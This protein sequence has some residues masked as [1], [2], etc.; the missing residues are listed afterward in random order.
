MRKKP[1]SDIS[2]RRWM[3]DGFR[4]VIKQWPQFLIGTMGILTVEFAVLCALPRMAF[5]STFP[6]NLALWTPPGGVWN[7]HE[8][9]VGAASLLVVYL[10]VLGMKNVAAEAASGG[11]PSTR[12][13][14]LPWRNVTRVLAALGYRSVA[15]G[16]RLLML[17]LP[18]IIEWLYCTF[19]PL[20]SLRHR[21]LGIRHS[22]DISRSRTDRVMIRL[23]IYR[24]L[25]VFMLGLAMESVLIGMMLENPTA[26]TVVTILAHLICVPLWTSSSGA[27]YVSL[28]CDEASEQSFSESAFQPASA[29]STTRSALLVLLAGLVVGALALGFVLRADRVLWPSMLEAV[30]E[31][32]RMDP[33]LADARIKVGDIVS[34]A[35]HPDGERI[36]VV[37]RCGLEMRRAADYALLEFVELPVPRYWEVPIALSEDGKLVAVGLE[38]DVLICDL[39]SLGS[40]P[41]HSLPLRAASLE[42]SS[43]GRLLYCAGY[44]DWLVSEVDVQS[45]QIIT[46]W[47]VED[48]VIQKLPG[49]CIEN[50]ETRARSRPIN[51]EINDE[52]TMLLLCTYDDVDPS[53]CGNLSVLYDLERDA[54]DR[55]LHGRLATFSDQAHILAMGRGTYDLETESESTMMDESQLRHFLRSDHDAW[56]VLSFENQR[57]VMRK[58]RVVSVRDLGSER[59]YDISLGYET[60]DTQPALIRCVGVQAAIPFA[61]RRTR[62][63]LLTSDEPDEECVIEPDAERLFA[64]SAERIRLW[65]LSEERLLYDFPNPGYRFTEMLHASESLALVAGRFGRPLL[66]LDPS[67][68][69]VA[70]LLPMEIVTAV[71]DE[72]GKFCAMLDERGQLSVWKSGDWSRPLYECGGFEF[73]RGGRVQNAELCFV[74]DEPLLWV[75]NGREVKQWHPEVDPHVLAEPEEAIDAKLCD[76]GVLYLDL[77]GQLHYQSLKT[78]EPSVAIATIRTEKPDACVSPSGRYVAYMPNA[79][80]V[81]VHDAHSGELTAFRPYGPERTEFEDFPGYSGLLGDRV[82]FLSDTYFAA[83]LN[84]PNDKDIG[85]WNGADNPTWREVVIVWDL[86]TGD[87]SFVSPRGLYR[88]VYPYPAIGG[89]AALTDYEVLLFEVPGMGDSDE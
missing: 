38:D 84:L 32:P 57:M 6:G 31:L 51:L 87:Q 60:S 35:F 2:V 7:L 72:T 28:G 17:L 37:T 46:D 83:I 20:V 53:W 85:A 21:H 54:V 70:G 5:F 77:A 59:Q 56:S 81:I 12:A 9:L 74:G 18:G 1:N 16:W 27:A 55:V 48:A 61:S 3:A 26:G 15:I 14:L 23:L 58:W 69:E 86:A 13:L 89:V 64:W 52:G 4:I 79:H 45:G 42:F 29:A 50:D 66:A 63:G 75:W 19:S 80:E 41:C 39:D 34:A 24:G 40:S 36:A 67:T 43:D 71:S 30:P 62:H 65:D 88:A 47:A 44:A 8:Y 25:L 78:E 68:I 49:L 22:A 10:F 11:T 76:D 33:G 82:C 73:V